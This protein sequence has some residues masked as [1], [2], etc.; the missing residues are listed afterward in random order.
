MSST[1]DVTLEN[2]E[3]VV[4]QGSLERPVVVDFWANWCA[5]CKQLGPVLERLSQE[6]DFVLAKVDTEKNQQLAAYFRISSIPDIR[7]FAQGQMVDAL[8]GALPEAQLRKALGKHFLS[9]ADK[10][11]LEAENLLQ[12]GQAEA[13]LPLID[14]LL[15]AKPSD[16]KVL[17]CKAK[18][19]VDLGQTDAAKDLLRQ[20]GEGDDFFREAKALGELMEFHQECARKDIADPT[21]IAYQQACALAL[22]GQYRESLEGFLAIVQSQKNWRDGAAR[23]AMLTLFGVLGAKHELTW[24]YRSRLNTILFI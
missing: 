8:Q 19:M 15:Q 24:E 23:K 5:P 22:Q 18:A 20:F 6:M 21:G 11:L 14:S 10:T 3:E 13:A 17:Y 4:I 16:K 9:E 2:F 7:V 12:Q 1:I